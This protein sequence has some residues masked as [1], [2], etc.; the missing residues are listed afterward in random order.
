METWIV[1]SSGGTRP[2]KRC[3][4]RHRIGVAWL[5][6]NGRATAIAS[7]L[8]TGVHSLSAVYMG[9]AMFTGLFSSPIVVTVKSVPP[10]VGSVRRGGPAFVLVTLDQAMNA[11]TAGNAS[12]YSLVALRKTRAGLVPVG[13]TIAVKRAMYD[14]SSHSVRLTPSIQLNP[15]V[16]YRLTI[17]GVTD[18][19]NTTLAGGSFIG[20]V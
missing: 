17:L 14:A 1:P 4:S 3:G 11:T 7:S 5:D 8:G 13:G 18:V 12:D 10:T 16:R 6:T 2:P 20:I 15:R 19:N 9:E